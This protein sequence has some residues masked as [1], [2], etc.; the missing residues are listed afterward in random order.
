MKLFFSIKT[1]F[2][3]CVLSSVASSSSWAQSVSK[4]TSPYSASRSADREATQQKRV[5]WARLREDETGTQ[6]HI[7][8]GY[9]DADAIILTS[10]SISP[11]DLLEEAKRLAREMDLPKTDFLHREG[12]QAYTV[13]LEFND[14]LIK[15]GRKMQWDF[16]LSRFS[17]ALERSQKLPRPIQILVHAEEAQGAEITTAQGVSLLT[18]PTFFALN[19]V[20][21]GSVLHFKRELSWFVYPLAFG[22]GA[23]LLGTF[24]SMPF[25]L[26][27]QIWRQQLKQR[28]QKEE[29]EAVLSPEAVQEAYNRQSPQIVTLLKLLG[30]PILVITCLSFGKN[31]FEQVLYALASHLPFMSNVRLFLPLIILWGGFSIF[32]VPKIARRLFDRRYGKPETPPEPNAG[33][34][35]LQNMIPFM[36][37]PV[38]GLFLFIGLTYTPILAHQKT[39]VRLW[40]SQGLIFGGMFIGA[41]V[42]V[43]R[44][45]RKQ[46]A[47][48]SGDFWYDETML[49][50][51]AANVTVKRV[52]T[53]PNP[54][55]NAGVTLGRSILLTKGLLE[56]MEPNEI[57]SVIAHEIGHLKHHHVRTGFWISLLF[58]IVVLGGWW[59][60]TAW[61]DPQVSRETA[62]LLHSPIFAIFV[63]PFLSNY[64][65]GKRRRRNE[66]QADAY[67]VEVTHD[68]ALVIHT[69]TKLHTLN[70]QPHH[71]KPSDEAIHTHPSLTHRIKAIQD[72]NL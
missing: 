28:T 70:A 34:A 5:G 51:K 31:T 56:K 13:D 71:L 37:F 12:R 15:Q 61:L 55:V 25:V 46:T 9:E 24:G 11:T 32:A 22:L 64:L 67:A 10:L 7:T 18:K 3:L 41:M 58:V 40:T 52:V 50:A 69:L 47:L 20:A 4:M 23:L 45:R 17:Q 62:A 19:E 2:V 57:R 49:L 43:R 39:S 14:Y 66:E 60:L 30:L 72:L 26:G 8:V 59:N 48:G 65:L 53:T 33:E 54:E 36:L 21:P 6:V 38:L 27:R 63:M 1:L 16:D 68:P 42:M 44:N 35:M 29:P